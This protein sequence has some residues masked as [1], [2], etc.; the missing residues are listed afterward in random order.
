MP[1]KDATV[2]LGGVSQN[3]AVVSGLKARSG[4]EFIVPEDAIYGG[5]IGCALIALQ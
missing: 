5:A 1:D 4:V 3:A 2:L